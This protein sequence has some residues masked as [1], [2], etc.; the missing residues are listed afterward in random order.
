MI[1][2]QQAIF[3][4]SQVCKATGLSKTSIYELIKQGKFKRPIQLSTRCVG[5]LS[6]D[7]E[8]FIAERVKASRPEIQ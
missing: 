1:S 4:I 2:T 7:I 6:S 8:E 3:R 5:W